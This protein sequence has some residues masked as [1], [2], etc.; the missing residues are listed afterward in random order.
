MKCTVEYIP[1]GNLCNLVR[2][3]PPCPGQ[4]LVPSTIHVY[5]TPTVCQAVCEYW[6]KIAHNANRDPLLLECILQHEKHV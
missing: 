5:G 3:P 6:A 1:G 4:D 2:C